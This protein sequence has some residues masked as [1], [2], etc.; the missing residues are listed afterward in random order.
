MNSRIVNVGILRAPEI[1]F[2]LNAPFVF[3]NHTLE[4]DCCIHVVNDQL[5]MTFSKGGIT[6]SIS[7]HEFSLQPN[8]A[9]ASFT[10]HDVV[11]GIGFHWQR[12]ENQTFAGTLRFIIE[13]GL[14]RAINSIDI[15]DYLLS[16]ISSEMSAEATSEFLK[17]HAVIS[18]SWLINRMNAVKNTANTISQISD[19]KVIRWYD[20]D[21]HMLFDVCADDHCQRYQ[22]ITRARE[23]ADRWDRV[24][25]VIDQTRGQVL[26]CDDEVCDARFSKCCGGRL[27]QYESCW[28]NTHK[29]YLI[30]KV[31]P[32]CNTSDKAVLSQV[33]NGYDQETID[34]Y[35]WTVT[36]SQSQLSEL[37]CRK[38]G[39]D[40]GDI[41]DL[42]TELRGPS[43]RIIELTI[44]GTKRTM[45]VGKE[46][47][48]RKWLSESHLYSSAFD[49]ERNADGDFILKGRGWG[50]GVGLCQIGAAVM[51]S[52]GFTYQQILLHYYPNTEIKTINE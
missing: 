4:G 42:R 3:E 23:S 39:Y 15:E 14:V 10:L 28:D 35:R 51:G 18:R 29:P 43:G 33:L 13:D 2:T 32:Y 46:L 24:R 30:T 25:S 44:V 45:T 37:I 8:D 52:Q 21:D 17:A 34:F 7:A 48:I 47:E 11:I 49:V 12:K 36:Y 19:T 9:D 5:E 1:R 20:H 40:F 50:H 38:S 41:T 6:T 16:V 22:G 26:M 27:E 31:D